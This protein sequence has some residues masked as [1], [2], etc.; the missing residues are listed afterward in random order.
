MRAVVVPRWPESP[1]AKQSVEELTDSAKEPGEVGTHLRELPELVSVQQ[2]LLQAA[3]I[4]VDLLGDVDQRAVALIDGLHMTVAPPQGNAVK[5]RRL[6]H[7]SCVP[8]SR[9]ARGSEPAPP[10]RPG[11][12]RPPPAPRSL[13]A[14]SSL[15]PRKG[16]TVPIVL[17]KPREPSPRPAPS[18]QSERPLPPPPP[19]RSA[20]YSRPPR[21]GHAHTA[22]RGGRVPAGDAPLRVFLE[23]RLRAGS[24]AVFLRS[25]PPRGVAQRAILEGA[26]LQKGPK[27]GRDRRP[28]GAEQLWSFHFT[29]R[30]FFFSLPF[31]K[32]TFSSGVRKYRPA[33]YLERGVTKES[34]LAFRHP[35]LPAP[36]APCPRTLAD[37]PDLRASSASRTYLRCLCH[38]LP[39]ATKSMD[40]SLQKSSKRCSEEK[41]DANGAL[42]HQFYLDPTLCLGS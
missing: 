20:S 5:H 29:H 21:T 37:R 3:G 24:G 30:A 35:L 38:L 7:Q 19:P 31:P 11:A 23:T 34:V 42:L 32:T 28:E 9:G 18:P 1:G 22:A 13:L 26:A 10:G 14:S 16:S 25:C 40:V 2:Q 4:A 12:P 15:A 8:P 27:A 33:A 39:G 41:G 36:L 17:R 6:R